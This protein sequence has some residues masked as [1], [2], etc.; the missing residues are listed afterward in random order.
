MNPEQLKARIEEL[1]E[2]VAFSAHMLTVQHALLMRLLAHQQAHLAAI[3]DLIVRSGEDRTMLAARLQSSYQ[4]ASSLYHDQYEQF[5]QSGDVGELLKTPAFP[6]DILGNF[7]ACLPPR[8]FPKLF[9]S[10]EN[11]SEA[12]DS[13]M[14]EA[15]SPSEPL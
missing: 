9:Y 1:T 15:L 11:K 6:D 7:L 5:L 13:R 3:R 2:T 14:G 12:T 4:S 10:P 8:P